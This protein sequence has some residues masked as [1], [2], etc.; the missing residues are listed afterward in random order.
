MRTTG[1]LQEY[2]AGFGRRLR[3]ALASRGAGAVA[4]AALLLTVVLVYLANRYAFSDSSVIGARTVLFAGLIA[5]VVALLARPLSRLAKRG[6]A[7]E[8][9][10]SVPA[11]NGRVTTYLDETKR[12][13]KT[14]AKNPL[15]DL[16]AE[17]AM[18]VAETAPVETIVTTGRIV[19]YVGL[20]VVAAAV[21]IWLGSAGPGYW[22]YGTAKLWAGWMMQDKPPLYDL[23]VE[24][25]D[26][27]VRSGAGLK[28]TAQPVGFDASNA[29]IAVKYAS[30][31]DWEDAPMA[32][33]AEGA[34]FEFSFTG[35]HEPFEYAITA[36]GIRSNEYQVRVVE[37]PNVENLKLTYKFPKWTGMEDLVE[38]PGGDIRAL[39]GTTVEVEVKTDKPLTGGVLTVN[40]NDLALKGGD[41]TVRAELTVSKDG[42]YHIAALYDGEHVRLTEDF[43]ITVTS[44]EKPQVKVL[45]PG[46]D[47]KAT[48]IEEV[49]AR[50]EATDDFGIG[51]FE[52]HYS[53]NGG[54]WT[55]VALK[56]RGRQ[57]RDS[58]VFYLEDMGV[59][60]T[61]MPDENEVGIQMLLPGGVQEQPLEPEKKE[62]RTVRRTLE[63]GDLISYYIAARDHAAAARTDMYFIEVQPFERTFQQSQQGGG[64]GGGQMNQ[65][66]EISKRQ[67]EI[68]TA[69][70]NLIQEQSADD[71]RSKAEIRESAQ[72]LS[73]L[74]LT[75]KEQAKTLAERTRARQMAGTNEK[76]R[77]FVENLEKAADAMQPASDQLAKNRLQDAV[78][79][80]QKA[81]QYLLRAESLFTDIQVAFQQGGGGGGGGGG[82]SQDLA[83]MFELE[84]DLEKNQ[85][86]TGGGGGQ[87]QQLER[88]IDDAFKKLEELARRQEQLAQQLRDQQDPS[89]AERW[90]QEMLRREAEELKRQLQQLQRQSQSQQAQ[91]QQQSQSGQQG[92]QG[93][94]GQQGQSGQ[95][96]G[97]SGQ[98][99]QQQQQALQRAIEQLERATKSMEQNASSQGQQ[100][101]GSPQ[102]QQQA[103]QRAQQELS[104]ALNQ[105]AEQRKRQ[106]QGA[107]SEI[108]QGV[109]DLVDRQE[110]MQPALQESLRKALAEMRKQQENGQRSRLSSGLSR[111]QERSLSE[112]KSG[113]AEDLQGIEREI[114]DTVRR[115]RETNPEAARKLRS[116]LGEMQQAEVTKRLQTAADYIRR[117]G[118]PYVASSEEG[119]SRALRQLREDVEEAQKLAQAG[120]EGGRQDELS[121]AL[122]QMQELRKS[123]EQAAGGDQ[124]GEQP[125]QGQQQGQQPGQQGQQGQQPGQGQGQ[126]QGQQQAQSGGP[127]GQ[128]PGQQ[129]GQGQ[130]S[131]QDGQQPGQQP[132]QQGSSPGQG[133]NQGQGTGQAQ[134]AQGGRQPGQQ[135]GRGSQ[136]MH[137][138][139]PR[140]GVGASNWGEWGPLRSG[141]P[142]DPATREQMEQALTQGVRELPRIT[143]D[144]RRGGLYEE[145]LEAIR[146]KA[147][148]LSSS[149]FK[150]NPELLEREYRSVLSLLEQ[151]ELQVRRKVETEEGGDVRVIVSEPVPDEYREA[152]AEYFRRLSRDA[153]Q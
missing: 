49:T 41:L 71:G 15:L 103:A 73:E 84:M 68:I 5:A 20:A 82:M 135:I 132:G 23:I 150:N 60:E 69:T 117:G 44:D 104:Q 121:R 81:L 91:S 124:Q 108:A 101:S 53:V 22:G 52:L 46:R 119:V 7:G 109:E 83:E 54:E 17:D 151:L 47:W 141:G 56:G 136:G 97:Q 122:A 39:V 146:K 87:Q 66:N 99:Q 140:R 137:E 61:E 149:K 34:G 110:A 6:V 147:R 57:V 16:L 79:P 25:G 128:Q 153:E 51:S 112:E 36:G 32:R 93:Q 64:G 67:K 55:K 4:L 78:Q 129:P 45:K 90:Q 100:Q 26:A 148:E 76:F 24:P 113:M 95:S 89:F 130:Q 28:V 18:K 74:Q 105:L 2:V 14:G 85:Y 62:P 123:L 125:G 142:V 12:A 118:A 31:V 40:E 13:Q 115:M 33:T 131:G 70:W 1:N 102:Q 134:T 145:D 75:L 111:E 10:K 19:S 120:G 144:L 48:S 35:I 21:L 94:P 29:E 114:Q 138:G 27:T 43:F 65:Q 72:M 139:G 58:H 42:E 107:L 80:E 127:G 8:I 133:N 116:A 50:F 63:P 9:E 11:F 126:Q 59:I 98:R 30:S 143:N 3:L 38:D 152:V 96:G 92:Q 37:M 86:E 106:N 88:E 77:A